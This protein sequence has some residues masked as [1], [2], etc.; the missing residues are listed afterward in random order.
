MDDLP[1]LPPERPLNT[2]VRA[3]FVM[4][5]TPLHAW[6]GE[7]GVDPAPAYKA[8]T[9]GWK[10]PAGRALVERLK[11]AAGVQDT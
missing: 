7:N 2:R 5:G 11:A 9:G 8:L 10:I 6:C 4:K 1:E 3:A